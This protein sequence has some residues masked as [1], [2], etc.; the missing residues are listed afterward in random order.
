MDT[1]VSNKLKSLGND[2]FLTEFNV[3]NNTSG[4]IDFDL[5][6]SNT[7]IEVPTTPQIIPSTQLGLSLTLPNDIRYSLG[8]GNL[9]YLIQ[10]SSPTGSNIQVY[11]LNANSLVSQTNFGGT[12]FRNIIYNPNNNSLYCPCGLTN[13][14]YE[15]DASTLL[16]TN[17]YSVPVGT[18][19]TLV[20][21]VGIQLNPSIGVN[22]AVY[23]LVL[24]GTTR[25]CTL[26]CDTGSTNNVLTLPFNL[27]S[28]SSFLYANNKLYFSITIFVSTRIL[29]ILNATLSPTII[30]N[31]SFTPNGISQSV[32]NTQNN[33]IYTV[34]QSG[35]LSIV[36]GSTNNLIQIINLPTT[37]PTGT[38]LTPRFLAYNPVDNIIYILTTTFVVINFYCDTNTSLLDTNANTY[39]TSPR[40]IIYNNYNNSYFF[41]YP[42]GFSPSWQLITQSTVVNPAPTYVSG[43][44]YS[45]NQFNEDKKNTPF[46]V[47]SVML[48]SDNPSN[49]NQV[50]FATVKDA[51]GEITYDPKLPA[52]DISANQYQASVTYVDFG[53]KGFVLNQESS[54]T[55]FTIQPFSSVNL[56]LI[57]KQFKTNSEF[58]NPKSNMDAIINDIGLYPIPNPDKTKIVRDSVRAVPLNTPTPTPAP[59]PTKKKKPLKPNKCAELWKDNYGI[60]GSEEINLQN[61]KSEILGLPTKFVGLGVGLLAVVGS[62][63][64]YKTK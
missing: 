51:T 57:Q 3:V 28:T 22:G 48:Y 38:P 62:I 37:S 39:T 54:F 41:S 56:I 35:Y 61:Q 7:L 19:I 45:Y 12:D 55:N 21:T 25:L 6:N 8:N 43:T 30:S 9:L 24:Q 20:A 44:N 4:V 2:Y 47:N 59:K 10:L 58:T 31:V 33:N 27:S 60:D 5:F 16:V 32:L 1:F 26:D 13:L 63:I 64:I 49:L 52:L 14:I 29:L 36:D 11:D 46:L 42:T 18:L 34:F 17:T 15:I 50:F 23:F 53:K 40:S